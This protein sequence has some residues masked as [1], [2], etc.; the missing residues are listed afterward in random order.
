[1]SEEF[2]RLV[3]IMERLRS[4]NGC[5]WD[6]KQDLDTLR[7]YLLEETYE[8]LEAMERWDWDSI[9]EELGDLLLQI[10][11]ISQIA[12]EKGKFTIDDVAKTIS[13]KL[14]HRHPHVF[15]NQK[16]ETPEEVEKSW[17]IL[18]RE[19]GKSPLPKKERGIPALLYAYRASKKASKLGFDWDDYRGA[20]EKVLEELEELKEAI[21][22]GSRLRKEEEVGDLLFACS[23]LSRL[24]KINPE[25][26]LRRSVDKFV[27]RFGEMVAEAGEPSKFKEMSIEEMDKLWESS[28][29]KELERKLKTLIKEKC[30]LY[31]PEKG[32]KLSSGKTSSFYIDCRKITF[33]A[34]GAFLVSKWVY[35]M[36]MKLGASAVGGPA[37]GSIPMVI[38]A[39]II[40]YM[41]GNCLRPVIFRKEKKEHGTGGTAIGHPQKGEKIVLI[42]D[43]VTTGKSLKKALLEARDMGLDVVGFLCLV[44]RREEKGPLFELPLVSLTTLDEL[45]ESHS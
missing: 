35:K 29:E 43:V 15:G 31:D 8:L 44:D 16:K 36:A 26:A 1:M 2:D 25:E 19:E 28:K 7:P 30:F 38:G 3:S 20:M 22:E 23:N 10:V 9:K 34:E 41:E 32:F 27:E 40:S 5:P 42:D 12:R 17:E 11:F 39:C 24:I 45:K 37:Y 18:K 6:R 21:K 33:T 14:I 13:D 4:K